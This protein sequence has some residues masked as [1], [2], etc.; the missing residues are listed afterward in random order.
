MVWTAA[1]ERRLGR[2]GAV[3]RNIFNGRTRL[4][5]AAAAVFERRLGG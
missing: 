1:R 5:A 2:S 3:V 4:D